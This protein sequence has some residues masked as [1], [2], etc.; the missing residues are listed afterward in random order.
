MI[1]E[2]KI[3]R[4]KRLLESPLYIAAFFPARL[5]ALQNK[6]LKL[7]D[8][9]IPFVRNTFAR[10]PLGDE[11]G[12]DGRVGGFVSEERGMSIVGGGSCREE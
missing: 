4:K 7:R 5:P 2:S 8:V 6:K 10:R 12:S 1:I 3:I 9:L 11:S